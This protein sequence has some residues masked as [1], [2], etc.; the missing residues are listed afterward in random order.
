MK[1]W[2]CHLRLLQCCYED[3]LSSAAAVSRTQIT[4]CCSHGFIDRY[5]RIYYTHIT[6]H[7]FHVSSVSVGVWI[8]SR[9]VVQCCCYW[10]IC[11]HLMLWTCVINVV[12]PWISHI[13]GTTLA[14]DKEKWNDHV[15]Y[16]VL[17][18]RHRGRFVHQCK[19]Q[20]IQ[21]YPVSP[22]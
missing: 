1:T 21:S 19:S 8:H 14:G 13:I 2:T 12:E 10:M 18:W 4:S 7:I 20:I 17:L 3:Q 16:S 9:S 22:I 5:S 6:L 11:M 15:Y